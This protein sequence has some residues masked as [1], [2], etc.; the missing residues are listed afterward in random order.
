MPGA[1]AR[2]STFALNNVTLP[3]VLELAENGARRALGRDPHLRK[4]LNV[5]EGQ[6]THR[7]VADALGLKNL[8][9]ATARAS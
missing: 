9:V 4:G 7:A 5:Y 8:N 6:V 3:F 1:V 2:T